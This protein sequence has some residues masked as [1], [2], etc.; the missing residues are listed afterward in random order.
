[1]IVGT[2]LISLIRGGKPHEKNDGHTP[3]GWS[4]EFKDDISAYAKVISQNEDMLLRLT[5]GLPRDC[6]GSERT[7][8]ML[9]K[10]KDEKP[11]KENSGSS[12][13]L[14]PNEV[15]VG[16]HARNFSIA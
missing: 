9:Q 14:E 3:S 10:C 6:M 15:Q 1:M 11:H 8:V 4:K 12:V 2:T 13:I 16:R 7:L 5:M